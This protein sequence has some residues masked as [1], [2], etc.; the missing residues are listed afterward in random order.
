MGNRDLRIRREGSQLKK[1][2]VRVNALR[3]Q[4]VS[5]LVPVTPQAAR[6]SV[7]VYRREGKGVCGEWEQ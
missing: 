2:F 1:G 3:K 7:I 4:V 5:S 6:K